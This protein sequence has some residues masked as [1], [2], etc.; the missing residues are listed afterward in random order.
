MGKFKNILILGANGQLGTDLVKVFADSGV[1]GLTHQD[2]EITDKNQ[3]ESAIEQYKPQVI[4]NTAAFHNTVECEV[5]PEK[6][7]LVNAVAVKFLAEACNKKSIV[8]AHIGSDYIFDGK[9]QKPYVESD[10]PNPLN[11]YGASKLAGEFFAAK[12][13]KYY[14]VR[15][16][17]VFG[18]AG[19]RA[20]NGKN[21]V[22]SMLESAKTKNVLQVTSNI[23]SSPTYTKDA[24]GRIK[25]IIFNQ[26]PYGIYHVVNSGQCSWH[27][28]ALEIFKQ[29]NI[30]VKVEEKLE[31]EQSAGIKRPM[32]SV[33]TSSKLPPMGSW[34]EALKDY[35]VERKER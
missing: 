18:V 2:I 21:F 5:Q 28:F 23:F 27:E 33:L 20:K 3:V 11:V 4:I 9:K 16:A 15:I 22:E 10:A 29:K 19:C 6:S 8:L 25:E 30:S 31:T 1:I 35:L 12:A 32:Y 13:D 26:M 24:A 14:V 7:F 17:S 34:Q